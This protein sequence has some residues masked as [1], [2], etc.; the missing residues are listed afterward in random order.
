MPIAAGGQ[1]E[2]HGC[3]SRSA[4]WLEATVVAQHGRDDAGGAVGRRRDD[5][6]AGGILLVHRQREQIHPVHDVERTPLRRLLQ[7]HAIHAWRATAHLEHA[8]QHAVGWRSPRSMQP[9]MTSRS[10]EQRRARLG[11][12]A[13]TARSFSSISSALETALRA[14]CQQLCADCKGMRQHRPRGPPL[15]LL[16]SPPRTMKPPPME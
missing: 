6:P 7:Q 15:Q 9:S 10:V 13:P 2:A 4:P 12:V 16:G 8:R 14:T 1:Q 5:A 3:R 11:I